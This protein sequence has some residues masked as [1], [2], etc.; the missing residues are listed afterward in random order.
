MS[1]Q[2]GY[3]SKAYRGAT[4]IPYVSSITPPEPTRAK[5]DRTHLESPSFTKENVAGFIELPEVTYVCVAVDGNAVQNLIES[6]F[7]AGTQTPE[8]WSHLICDPSTGA[9]QRTYSYS[10]YISSCLRA[11][12]EPEAGID[13]TIKI[14]L[15]SAVTIT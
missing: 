14:Q 15:S 7:Y 11:P 4:Q 3:R 10:G 5:I 1:G 9:T 8:A 12:I 2:I 6:D 13:L